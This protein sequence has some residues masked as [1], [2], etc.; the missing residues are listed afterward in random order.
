LSLRIG[1]LGTPGAG[2]YKIVGNWDDDRQI[3]EPPMCAKEI[4]TFT[5]ATTVK[6]TQ[7]MLRFGRDSNWP[8]KITLAAR[9]SQA[10]VVS[11]TYEIDWEGLE[12]TDEGDISTDWGL[13]KFRGKYEEESLMAPPALASGQG[14]WDATVRKENNSMRIIFK[15]QGIWAPEDPD[16]PPPMILYG[17]K[18]IVKIRPIRHRKRSS[19]SRVGIDC[20]VRRRSHSDA[21]LKRPSTG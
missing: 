21:P 12:T 3:P 5:E 20:I 18:A 13:T 10:T 7:A 17:P 14:V 9:A 8:L 15:E 6:E 19:L 11:I 4:P 2:V 16:G 1:E